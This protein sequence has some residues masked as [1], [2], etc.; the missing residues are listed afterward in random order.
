M[1]GNNGFFAVDRNAFAQACDSGIN[2]A[3]AFLTM[4]CGTSGDNRTTTWS[5]TAVAKYAGMRWRKANE[6]IEELT[7]SGL[8]VRVGGKG[9]LR[10]YEINVTRL[11]TWLPRTLIEGARDEMPLKT[12]RQ[13]HDTSLLRLLIGLYAAHELREEGGLPLDMMHAPYNRTRIGAGRQFVVWGFDAGPQTVYPNHA[14]IR[15]HFDPDDEAAFWERM[16]ALSDLRFLDCVP[17]LYD[18][19]QGE[20][21]VA[22]DDEGIQTAVWQA[23]NCLLPEEYERAIEEHAPVVPVE[24][25]LKQVQMI[26]VYRLRYRPYTT[27]TSAWWDEHIEA[28]RVFER[29]MK[30]V[31]NQEV[32]SAVA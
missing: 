17:T 19:P 24:R 7:D 16:S 23:T 8:V 20:R 10:R 31:T 11:D 26:G 1:A 3:C 28:K 9:T 25:H 21:I 30:G 14:G 18:G 27:A 2:A 32:I 22:L 5:A 4:A 12:L 15:E 29:K 6:A 13:T